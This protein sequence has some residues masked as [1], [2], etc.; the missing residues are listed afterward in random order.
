[1][2]SSGLASGLTGLAE[3]TAG[4]EIEGYRPVYTLALN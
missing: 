3:L 4:A 2:S 1:M